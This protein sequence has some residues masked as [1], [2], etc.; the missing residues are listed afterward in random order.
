MWSCT[1]KHTNTL[2]CVV[3]P[4]AIGKTS[5]AIKLAKHF[6]SEIISADSRQFFKEMNIGTAV[7][8]EDELTQA[9]HH[10]I[11]N[12]SI[13]ENYN[14][15]KY[16][17]EALAIL[18]ELFQ[19]NRVQILVGGSGLYVNAVTKGLDDF[20][21]IDATVRNQINEEYN[22]KGISFLQEKLKT[23]DPSYFNFIALNNPQ[24]LQNPQRMKRFVEVCLGTGKPY[25]SYLGKK[26][27]Q[28]KFNVVYLGIEAPREV[29]YQRINQ[30]V[31]IMMANGLLEEVKK[32]IPYQSNNALQ[33]VGYQELFA[34]FDGKCSIEEAIE[35]IKQNT[36]R[37]AKRQLTW[38]KK[39]TNTLWVD[40]SED[41][42]SI[43]HK[44]EQKLEEFN[45]VI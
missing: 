5:L 9:P 7:P 32:L 11:Q 27:L 20:P 41:L 23:L 19:K 12:K 44:M 31:D 43:L 14:V 15:G 35:Q 37:F 6:G 25:S 36:R 28:R 24:T 22:E 16:E 1:M 39:E 34:Y 26:S 21:E 10:F 17:V 8:S 30:R 33:T 45:H 42:K 13:F 29:I 40:Y 2:I 3:G 38:F 18:P 4:T